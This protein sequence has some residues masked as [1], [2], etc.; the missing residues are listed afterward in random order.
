MTL[1]KLKMLGLALMLAAV[2]SLA[3][4]GFVRAGLSKIGADPALFAGGQ[5]PK[6]VAETSKAKQLDLRV[7]RRS[8]KQPISGATVEASTSDRG[9]WQEKALSTDNQGRCSIELRGATSAL[10]VFVAKDG[11]VPILQSWKEADLRGVVPEMYTLELEPGEPIG[12]FVKDEQGR[13]IGGAEVIVAISQRKDDVPD[14]DVAMPANLRV[15]A[16]F[17]HMRVHTDDQ[18][19]WQCSI[20]PVN[21]DPTTRLWFFV[22]HPD[23]LSDTGGYARRLSLKT[24]RA[25]TGALIISRGEGIRGQVRDGNDR[26]V[27]GA[28]VVLAYSGSSGDSLKTTTDAEGRYQFL[29]ANDRNGLGRWSL[30]VEAPG[31]A[32][33]WKMIVPKGEIPPADFRL[34]PGRP[35][36]GRVIDPHGRPVGG[37]AVS[38]RWEECYSL[39]WKAET[40]AEGRFVWPDAP[41]EGEIEFNLRKAGFNVALD[42]T[43]PAAAGQA[44]LTINP[45][46]RARGKVVDVGSKQPV[47]SFTVI[48]ATQYPGYREI[49]WQRSRAV[50]GRE[51]QYEIAVSHLDQPGTVFQLRIEAEGYAP[52]TSRPIQPGEGG[53]TL[54]FELKKA[55]GIS[56][57]V[58][59]PDG[60]P[61]PG[62]DVYIDAYGFINNRPEL[63][64]ASGRF[65]ARRRKTGPDGRYA[66]PPQDEPSGILVI[67]DK[68]FGNRTAEEMARSADLRL[69]PWAR[70]E[71]TFRIRGNPGIHRQIEINLIRNTIDPS[72]SFQSYKTMTDDQGRFVI[73]RIMDGEANFKWSNGQTVTRAESSA[74][75]AVDIRPGQTLRVEL[76]G[77]GRPLIGQVVLAMAQGV[78]KGEGH[79][80]V[81]LAN[82]SGWLESRPA[83]MPIPQD[84]ATW[85]VKKQRAYKVKWY[86]TEPGK[87]YLRDRRYHIF[88]VGA[89]GRFRI[90]DVVSGSYNMRISIQRTPGITHAHTRDRVEGRIERDLEVG[91]IP[92]GHSDEPMDLGTIPMKVEVKH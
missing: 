8:D 23:H 32:P 48:P 67:H 66:F 14:E 65:D 30:S 80:P 39:D 63:P 3:V 19:R 58:R 37:V 49:D 76:G 2:G 78:G 88:P 51:G 9:T 44:E 38:A 1:S 64:P 36:R 84:F 50:T 47:S 33:S 82:A 77:Q 15:Y 61:A 91:A 59:L 85:D 83:L 46:L 25:M 20:L 56:G 29:H 75:P 22:K 55:D 26:P 60:T 52:A 6:A 41:A 70:I 17:P 5:T 27:A 31:F 28:T 13:P 57:V 10:A 45:P 53:V 16:G 86:Q 7:V 73:E 21:A 62:A 90:E 42:R 11:F 35:F 69:K 92:G 54:D 34:T 81:N 89:D 79:A 43:A 68:G 72:Y 71:G 4:G 87:A 40:D 24:A 18:G 12:G 74:G